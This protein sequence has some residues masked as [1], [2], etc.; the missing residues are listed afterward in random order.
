MAWMNRKLHP[1][2]EV[3]FMLPDERH[4]Y[5]SSSLVRELIRLGGAV[6]G[7]VPRVVEA[8]IQKKMGRSE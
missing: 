3:V 5:L 4:S 2:Y 6:R 8:E 1:G 7:F